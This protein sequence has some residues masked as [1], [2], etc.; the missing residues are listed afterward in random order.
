MSHRPEGDD[1]SPGGFARYARG[2]DYHKVV[3]R[4]LSKLGAAVEQ[5][6]G[7]APDSTRA[8]SDSAVS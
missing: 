6:L 3:R 1:E 7:L 5:E 2:S 8:F 4:R